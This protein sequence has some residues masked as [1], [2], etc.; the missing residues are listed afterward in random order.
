MKAYQIARAITFILA[1]ALGLWGL[2]S[3]WEVINNNM[4]PGYV[5]HAWNM[6]ALLF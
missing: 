3:W 6:F 5:Y 1:I 4:T 2:V